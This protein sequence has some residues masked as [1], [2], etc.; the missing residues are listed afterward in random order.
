M[1]SRYNHLF[2]LGR[3]AVD[4]TNANLGLA[5]G[6][7]IRHGAIFTHL[8][9]TLGQTAGQIM[10]QRH[11]GLCLV[12]CITEHHALIART[13]LVIRINSFTV[14][15]FPRFV[16]ALRNIGRLL[17][18]GIQ[19]TAGIAVETV[20]G[21]IVSDFTEHLAGNSRHINIGLSAHLA[22]N[23]NKTSGSHGF[24]RAAN[25][26]RVGGNAARS[27]IASCCQ[28]GFLGENGIEDG[29]GDLVAD[30]IRVA[31]GYRFARKQVRML[32]FLH[33]SFPFRKTGGSQ[34]YLPTTFR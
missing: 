16:N 10:R 24:H 26:F 23:H 32:F 8:R 12:A 29:I 14:L 31:F 5:V 21:A 30:L 34:S 25:L 20:L 13:D 6:T 18:D 28:L 7:Q 19:H 4:V 1:L 33:L 9:K 3:N 17:V 2:N 11:K 22:G 15:R 27:N